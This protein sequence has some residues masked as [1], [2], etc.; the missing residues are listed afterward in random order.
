MVAEVLLVALLH[1]LPLRYLKVVPVAA[2]Y[3][4]Q[5][6]LRAALLHHKALLS[7]VHPAQ[8]LL[9]RLWLPVVF[10]LLP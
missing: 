5:A 1:L 6:R 9:A 3:R 8:R 7:A 4:P 2:Q 10:L